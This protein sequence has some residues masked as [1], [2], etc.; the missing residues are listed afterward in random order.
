METL[1]SDTLRA[2]GERGF[3]THYFESASSMRDF[4]L[5]MVPPKASVGFGGSVTTE[6][7][8]LYEALRERGCAVHFHWKEPRENRT[9]VFEAARKADVYIMSSNAVSADGALLNIDGNGNR[10]GSLVD[11]PKT[12][13]ILL[14][15]NKLAQSRAEAFK[16]VKTVACPSNARRLGLDTPCARTGTCTDCRS[17]QRMCNSIVWTEAPRK[18]AT[19]HVCVAACEMGF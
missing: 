4:V 8:G 11:G 15:V 7:L 19:V 1:V 18:G 13:F 2:L 12:V 17:P 14:G 16:R 6:E 9:A 5:E 3:N 10:V